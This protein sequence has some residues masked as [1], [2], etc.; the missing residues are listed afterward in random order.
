M[1]ADKASPPVLPNGSS[2]D[3]TKQSSN[4]A[5][6]RKP[7]TLTKPDGSGSKSSSP[8]QPSPDE[9]LPPPDIRKL[10]DN[11]H[12]TILRLCKKNEWGQADSILRTLS[13]GAPEVNFSLVSVE[14][15][16]K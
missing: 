15:N 1:S 7:Q 8:E 16:F 9:T 3:K 11:P 14:K 5:T 4:I 12:A 10:S 13:K 2:S 6:P